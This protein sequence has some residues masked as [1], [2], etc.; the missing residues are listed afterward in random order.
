M[1]TLDDIAPAEVHCCECGKAIPRIPVWLVSAKTVKFQCEECRQKNPRIPTPDPGPV[2]HH[3]DEEDEAPAPISLEGVDDEEAEPDE[4][5][6][7][8]PVYG[9]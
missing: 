3:Q 6:P 9:E 5:L 4:E 1:T 8:D 7:D 2:R